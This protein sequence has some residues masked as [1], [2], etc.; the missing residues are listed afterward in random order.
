MG[1]VPLRGNTQPSIIKELTGNTN[2][3]L[4]TVLDKTVRLYSES[5]QLVKAWPK[6]SE[7][8]KTAINALVRTRK[9]PS[10]RQLG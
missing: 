6:L 8:T 3:V 2:S 10:R 1:V 7:D 4:S 5:V 9:A